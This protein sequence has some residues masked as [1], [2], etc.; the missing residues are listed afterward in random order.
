MGVEVTDTFEKFA[1]S[2]IKACILYFMFL[3]WMNN[4]E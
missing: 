2:L 3:V 4:V 1:G